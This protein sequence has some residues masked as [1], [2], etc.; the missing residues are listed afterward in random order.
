MSR[1]LQSFS[2]GHIREHLRRTMALSSSDNLTGRKQWSSTIRRSGKRS[3]IVSTTGITT[4]DPHGRRLDVDE[5]AEIVGQRPG[6]E[7]RR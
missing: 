5:Q 3:A 6:F 4:S 1:T 7:R 2:S